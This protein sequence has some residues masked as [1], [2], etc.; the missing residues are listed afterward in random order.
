MYMAIFIAPDKGA[1]FQPK[2]PNTC[3]F[4]ISPR[5]HMFW[6]LLEA[7][8]QG[9]YRGTTIYVLHGEIRKILRGDPHWS[10]AHFMPIIGV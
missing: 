3:I 1:F 9:D 8:Q 4:L 7:H 2:I 6:F 5:K 10:H